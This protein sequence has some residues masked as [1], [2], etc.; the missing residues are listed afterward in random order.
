MNRIFCFIYING[1]ENSMFSSIIY[2]YIEED[3]NNNIN[4]GFSVTHFSSVKANMG[5]LLLRVSTISFFQKASNKNPLL[6]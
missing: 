4:F 5:H 6:Y 2:F 1:T 3:V